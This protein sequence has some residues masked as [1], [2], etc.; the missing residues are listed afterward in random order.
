MRVCLVRRVQRQ[1][2][3]KEKMSETPEESQ[4]KLGTKQFPLFLVFEKKCAHP[5]GSEWC[6]SVVFSSCFFWS[7][8]WVFRDF[9]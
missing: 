4:E 6:I 1:E 7:I 2:K 3:I 9:L 8:W 5:Q